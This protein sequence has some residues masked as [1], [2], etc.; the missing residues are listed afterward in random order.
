[1]STFDTI[2]PAPVEVPLGRRA[3]AG[4]LDVASAAAACFVLLD[5]ALSFGAPWPVA[6]TLAAVG[7]TLLWGLSESRGWGALGR[8]A[9]GLEVRNL[10]ASRPS[11]R[12]AVVR[13]APLGLLVSGAVLV[14]PGLALI[15]LALG[16]IDLAGRGQP[17]NRTLRDR[18]SGTV[19]VSKQTAAAS[20]RIA[21][22]AYLES[23]APMRYRGED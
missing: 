16:L 1:M 5:V 19:V 6:W 4:F 20:E 9:T 11:V 14:A 12:K 15:A 17:F 21:G 18:W 8:F 3:A 2:P 7:P 23:G 22:F 10:D 13:Q